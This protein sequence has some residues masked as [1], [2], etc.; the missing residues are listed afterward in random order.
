MKI[1]LNDDICSL[2]NFAS[3]YVCTERPDIGTE[4]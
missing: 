3:Y 4:F 1:F 2:S